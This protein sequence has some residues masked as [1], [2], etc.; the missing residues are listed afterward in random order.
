VFIFRFFQRMAEGHYTNNQLLL[1][2]MPDFNAI[3]LT[4]S[5]V[6]EGLKEDRP[7]NSLSF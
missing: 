5:Y 3:D 7:V 6:E 2:Q 4:L 1:T